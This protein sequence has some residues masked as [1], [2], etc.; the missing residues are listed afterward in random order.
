MTVGASSAPA[1][2]VGK[3]RGFFN[4]LAAAC[5]RL[6]RGLMRE[7][8]GVRRRHVEIVWNGERNIKVWIM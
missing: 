6:E 3:K 2:M 7:R 4:D 5:P 1:A 8:A